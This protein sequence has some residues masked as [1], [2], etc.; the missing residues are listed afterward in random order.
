[1]LES[2][3]ILPSSL[4]EPFVSGFDATLQANFDTLHDSE[5]SV[6]SFQFYTSV[7][8]VFSSK[9]E[10][11][12]I[13]LDSFVKHR[14]QTAQYEPDY[15]QKIDDLYD[16]YLFAQKNDLTTANLLESHKL[17]TQNILREKSR[18][19]LRTGNM[20]VITDD[21]KIEYVAAT[22]DKVSVEMDKFTSDL[23][24]LL[25]TELDFAQTFYFAAMLHLVFVK[26]HPFEDGNGRSAR[27]LEKW[28][29]AQKLG[30]KAWFLQSEKLYYNQHSVYYA[31]I[32]KLGLEYD[33][34]DYA[35][36]LP[37]LEMLPQS[38]KP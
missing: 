27:L 14:T 30:E 17:L 22:P 11:E 2:F 4:L 31:N 15:T 26:I 34:L 6:E 13:N 8:A 19:T 16:A 23:Q 28:F 21:G 24:T 7:S 32:R 9:I 38:L 25:S 18:G 29:L 3:K 20:F 36:A 37:F 1:M 5:L 10:G 35:N 12:D 33:F